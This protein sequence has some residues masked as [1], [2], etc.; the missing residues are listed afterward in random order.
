MQ[1]FDAN[2]FPMPFHYKHFNWRSFFFVWLDAE[3]VMVLVWLPRLTLDAQ[4]HFCVECSEQMLS[5]IEAFPSRATAIE[6]FLRYSTQSHSFQSKSYL[7]ALKLHRL[8][9]PEK[10]FAHY[11]NISSYQWA[12]RNFYWKI[13]C[14]CD[15]KT[16]N[17]LL[18]V[19]KRN[20]SLWKLISLDVQLW[21]FAFALIA[22]PICII[23]PQINRFNAAELW[24][25]VST[26]RG[27]F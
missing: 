24:I 9:F 1:N 7:P 18:I 14:Q 19:Y 27:G 2:F 6:C 15:R 23:E 10:Q 20:L 26:S 17:N 8:P 5:S 21:L 13:Y 3:F 25:K 16:E 11:A 12:T 4:L 22:A